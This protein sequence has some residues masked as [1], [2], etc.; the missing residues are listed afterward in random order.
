M[1][2]D[3]AVAWLLE[4]D[5]DNPSIRYYALR[6]LLGEP[7]EAL[8]VRRA[9]RAIMRSGTVPRILAAQKTGGN[10]IPRSARYQNSPTQIYLL[11]ELGADPRDKRVRAGCEYLLTHAIASN[12]AIAAWSERPLPSKVLHCDNAPLVRAFLRLGFG[13]D[14]RVQT[15]MDWQVRAILGKLPPAGY[16]K[17]G[18]AGPNF[19][20]SV[21]QGQPCAWGATKA[22]RAL[23]AVPKKERTPL[24]RQAV[25]AGAEFLLSHDLATADYPYT[26]RISSTWFKFGFPLSY[27]SDILETAEV[28]VDLGYARDP[29]LARAFD[30]ILSKQDSEGRWKLE[31]SLNGKMWADIEVKGRPSKWVTLRALRLLKQAGYTNS[32]KYRTRISPTIDE[33]RNV[34]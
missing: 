1:R 24:M 21:N 10:W 12:G 30:L 19:A 27:W 22:L 20:C 3:N 23:A 2:T 26:G 14:K 7:E 28:L 29:R 17:S 11:S 32:L 6:D 18:T 8:Q 15:A 4:P 13:E 16:F 25:K 9:R 5:P 33:A 31:N 34:L